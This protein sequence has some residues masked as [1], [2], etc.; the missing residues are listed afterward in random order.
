MLERELVNEAPAIAHCWCA[1][2]GTF[3]NLI[4]CKE[5]Q[6]PF[7][8]LTLPRWAISDFSFHVPPPHWSPP[9]QAHAKPGSHFLLTRFPEDHTVSPLIPLKYCLQ[10]QGILNIHR[11][12]WPRC[13]PGS[14]QL[15]AAERASQLQAE[16]TV[17]VVCAGLTGC[18]ASSLLETAHCASVEGALPRWT[19]FSE[20][21]RR[22]WIR[23]V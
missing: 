18:P 9:K 17:L 20:A 7:I 15:R 5:Q 13:T 19:G 12:E 8:N 14:W 11:G 3:K 23:G 16:K 21:G 10:P 6:C 2:E 22:S 1:V 4:H